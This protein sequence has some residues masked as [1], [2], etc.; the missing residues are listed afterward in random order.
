MCFELITA[1]YLPSNYYLANVKT[2]SKVE[3]MNH[4]KK[5]LTCTQN[6]SAELMNIEIS[7]LS[8][9]INTVKGLSFFVKR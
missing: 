8:S 2:L 9:G 3:K 5:H 7:W 4:R 6:I 1:A